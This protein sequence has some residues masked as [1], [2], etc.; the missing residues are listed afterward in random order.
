MGFKFENISK[1][2]VWLFSI[3]IGLLVTLFAVWGA[4]KY[5]GKNRNIEKIDIVILPDSGVFFLNEQDVFNIVNRT[6]GNPKGKAAS[7][8]SLTKLET[9]L[10]SLPYIQSSQVYISLDGVMKIQI[11]QRKPIVRVT[12]TAGETFFMDTAGFKIPYRGKHAPDVLPATGNITE[13][14]AE[15]VQAKS[16]MLKQLLKLSI[17]IDANPLWNAQ[18]EQCHVDNSGDLILVPRVGKHS[19]VTGDAENL[20]EKFANLRQFYEKGLRNTGWDK[21]HTISLK[22][23]GQIVGIK[24]VNITEQKKENT[25]Q[26]DKH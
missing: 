17:F 16:A 25:V 11:V 13:K 18:F 3:L 19:I 20:P 14:L 4:L 10:K 15:S 9:T 5:S 24:S 22:Y 8:I 26:N 7:Q 23:R 1:S 6:C 2:R 21:Y 12:N